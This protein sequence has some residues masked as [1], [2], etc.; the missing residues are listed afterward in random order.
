MLDKLKSINFKSRNIKL[1]MAF[2]IPFVL[3]I[4]LT[5]GLLYEIK[6]SGVE[7]TKKVSWTTSVIHG[8]IYSVI[9][10]CFYYFYL[11]EKK[12]NV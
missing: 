2:I 9:L 12:S 1:G 6:K 4:A 5:P 3:Y 11:I 10:F 7:K 8:F